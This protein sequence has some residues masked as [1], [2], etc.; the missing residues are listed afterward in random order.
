MIEGMLQ[1]FLGPAKAEIDKLSKE[2]TPDVLL[3]AGFAKM[4][5]FVLLTCRAAGPPDGLAE[6]LG[7]NAERTRIVYEA[8]LTAAIQ[9]NL[10]AQRAQEVA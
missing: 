9:R 10:P 3:R 7:I 5:E 6:Q 2:Y 8:V 1:S 4:A